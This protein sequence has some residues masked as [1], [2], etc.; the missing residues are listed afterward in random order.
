[1][2]YLSLIRMLIFG[3]DQAGAEKGIRQWIH[4]LRQESKASSASS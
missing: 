4:F 1:M 3:R 2:I